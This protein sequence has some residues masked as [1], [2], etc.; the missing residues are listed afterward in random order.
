MSRTRRT[1]N[2]RHVVKA[3]R[4]QYEPRNADY[5]TDRSRRHQAA[6]LRG[7]D[8]AGYGSTKYAM[9]EID[10]A[11][12]VKAN[13]YSPIVTSKNGRRAAQKAQRAASKILIN[14][15]LNDE[16][17]IFE[18]IWLDQLD[19]DDNY[20]ET[21]QLPDWWYDMEDHHSDE[22]EDPKYFCL[23]DGWDDYRDADDWY[24][25]TQY[26]EAA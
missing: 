25:S 16:Q 21:M 7:D 8:G 23:E 1:V 11:G 14:V 10:R 12:S 20:N 9:F 17:D 2:Y 3:L 5:H 24:H 15:G 26:Y 4:D 19:Y 18:D 6:R 13:T 22:P